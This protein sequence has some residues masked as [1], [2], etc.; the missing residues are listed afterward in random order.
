MSWYYKRTGRAEK[1]AE[2]V[3][4]QFFETGGCPE[5]TAEEEA[6]NALGAVAETLC[7]S[8]IGNP[9]VVIEAGGSAWNNNGQAKHQQA[10]F[11]FETIG[12]FVE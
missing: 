5:G 7:K 10:S 11:K 2:V 12:D 1:L 4:Q 6:K 3:K 8:L 9:V